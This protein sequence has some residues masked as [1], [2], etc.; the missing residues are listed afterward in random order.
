MRAASPGPVRVPGRFP[1]EEVLATGRGPFGPLEIDFG[2]GT[3]FEMVA[4]CFPPRGLCD[5][6]RDRDREPPSVVEERPDHQ[7]GDRRRRR[8]TNGKP[9]QRFAGPISRAWDEPDRPGFAGGPRRKR[10]GAIGRGRSDTRSR[11]VSRSRTLAERWGSAASADS[12]ARRSRGSSS[13][14][15]YA[16]RTDSSSGLIMIVP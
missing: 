6:D 14:S 10:S 3:G 15:T 5:R 13:P 7:E 4:G 1:G 12:T 16:L 9:G 11:T 8:E 2:L